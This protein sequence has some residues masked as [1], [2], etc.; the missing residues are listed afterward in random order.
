M[1]KNHSTVQIVF[2]LHNK[3]ENPPAF[4]AT[5]SITKQKKRDMRRNNRRGGREKEKPKK[6]EDIKRL[7]GRR[8][9][10]LVPPPF[11]P[12]P[13]LFLLFIR[14]LSPPPQRHAAAFPSLSP[15]SRQNGK[16]WSPWSTSRLSYRLL[17]PIAVDSSRVLGLLNQK[18]KIRTKKRCY[19]PKQYTTYTRIPCI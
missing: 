9:T 12:P 8:E 7:T 4:S 5:T 14:P 16:N 1:E 10:I 17:C 13:R 2:N 15:G 6:I 11:F 19:K 18:A 3:T